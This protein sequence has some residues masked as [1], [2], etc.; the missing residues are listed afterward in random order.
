MESVGAAE[1]EEEEEEEEEEEDRVFRYNAFAA[2]GIAVAAGPF[3]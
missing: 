2:T 1:G 3:I